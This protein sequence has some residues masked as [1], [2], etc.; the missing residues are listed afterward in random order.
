MI[1]GM[2]LLL[3]EG[4]TSSCVGAERRDKSDLLTCLMVCKLV[5]WWLR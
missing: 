2:C 1:H 5:C 4:A 3:D